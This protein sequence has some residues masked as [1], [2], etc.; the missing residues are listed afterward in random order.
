MAFPL[1]TPR[2]D[3]CL[4][5]Y[6]HVLLMG[7]EIYEFGCERV[8]VLLSANDV[9][10]SKKYELSSRRIKCTVRHKGRTQETNP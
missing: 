9:L 8:Y 3:H 5:D 1:G 2:A 4:C 10:E 7:E 6:R